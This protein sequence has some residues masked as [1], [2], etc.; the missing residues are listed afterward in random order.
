MSVKWTETEKGLY[1]ASSLR[2]LAQGVLGNQPRDDRQNYAKLVKALQD[3][4]APLNQTELYR[5]S[6]E[7]E[8]RDHQ[9]VYRRWARR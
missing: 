2:G 7:I 5:L 9:R 4:F 8:D 6:L 3:R 1:L